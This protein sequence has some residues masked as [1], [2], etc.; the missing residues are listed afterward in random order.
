M[1]SR[2]GEDQETVRGTVS[3]TN[4]VEAVELGERRFEGEIATSGLKPLHQI[5]GAGVEHPV[6]GFDERMAYRAEQMRLAGT[7]VAYGDEVGAGQG[8]VAGGERLDA[9]ARHGGRRREVEGWG[10]TRIGPGDR[11]AAE[12]VL[13]PGRRD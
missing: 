13:P 3:P 9:G 12:R 6:T 4:E 7:G 11:S 5:G 1:S 2:S 8:P 10:G